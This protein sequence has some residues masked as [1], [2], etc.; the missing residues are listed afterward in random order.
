M[1]RNIQAESCK[2]FEYDEEVLA[3][4]KD[5]FLSLDEGTLSAKEFSNGRFVRNLFERTWAKAAMRRELSKG[6]LKIIKEDFLRSIADDEFKKSLQG[7]EHKR[8]GFGVIE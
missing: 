1:S 8:I 6:K 3:A 2:N 5:F 7:K 4:A